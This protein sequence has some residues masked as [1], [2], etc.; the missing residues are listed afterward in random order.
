MKWKK[1]AIYE[2]QGYNEERIDESGTDKENVC[3]RFVTRVLID[4]AR[5]KEINVESGKVTIKIPQGVQDGTELR[6]S[7][8][9]MPGP[10]NLPAGDLFITLRVSTP[11]IFQRFG[12]DLGVALELD[13]FKVVLGDVVNVPVVDLK[14][15]DG[16][17]T[18]QLKIPAGTQY[19]TQFRIR[20]KGMP[21][22]RGNG[23][24]DVIA[25]IYIKIPNK[26]TKKQKE[27]LEE[28][29]NAK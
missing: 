7:G 16:L 15:T 11:K 26:I 8:K 29:K 2:E 4:A 24:G 22:L 12:D 21:R 13:F 17:G 6:F 25:Q 1:D 20:G 27:L 18:A 28:Y 10:N 9:G 23:Q 14:S 5:E 3:S 19:G